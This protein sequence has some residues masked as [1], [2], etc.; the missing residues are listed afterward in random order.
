MRT[1]GLSGG[2]GECGRLLGME[3]DRIE[4]WESGWKEAEEERSSSSSIISWAY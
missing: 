1:V 2:G 4:I 3:R